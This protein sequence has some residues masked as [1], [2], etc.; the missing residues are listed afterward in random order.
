MLPEIYHTVPYSYKESRTIVLVVIQVQIGV[1]EKLLYSRADFD[2]SRGKTVVPSL[3]TSPHGPDVNPGF[4]PGGSR[5][6]KQSLSGSGGGNMGSI[7]GSSVMI[8]DYPSTQNPKISKPEDPLPSLPTA[9]VINLCE[10]GSPYPSCKQEAVH[11]TVLSGLIHHDGK[12][13]VQV[14]GLT[15]FRY[16]GYDAYLGIQ[17]LGSSLR[18]K[19]NL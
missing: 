6:R 3:T 8:T 13:T 14:S 17:D 9:L 2:V 1:I 11:N 5:G 10:K 12:P 4:R 7:E 18:F 19:F 15:A 16:L